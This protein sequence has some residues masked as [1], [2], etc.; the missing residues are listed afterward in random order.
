[1]NERIQVVLKAV[2]SRQGAIVVLW[3]VFMA[4]S[5]AILSRVVT[6]VREREENYIK[7]WTDAMSRIGSLDPQD[8]LV[9]MVMSGDIPFIMINDRGI[10]EAFSRS[11][12]EKIINTPKL[13]DKQIWR[14]QN[15]NGYIDIHFWDGS[16][17][18]VFY[19]K[20]KT[21]VFLTFFPVMQVAAFALLL[22]LGVFTFR[23]NKINEQNRVWVGL[24]K[25]TAHQLGTPTSSLLGWIEYLRTQPIDPEAVEEMGKDLTHLMKIADRFS[26]IGS[27]TPLNP[28]NINEVVGE[29]VMYFRKRIPKNVELNY[30]GLAMAPVRAR[31]NPALF[32]WVIENLLKNALDALQGRGTIDV[33]ISHDERNIFID[34]A[35]SGKGI[36]RSNWKKIFEPGFTTKTRGWGLGLS[37]SHRV[38]EEYHKGRIFVAESEVGNGTTMRVILKLLNS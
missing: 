6:K 17:H 36:P 2:F 21:L 7:L 9:N 12:P 18:R 15:M 34:V 33:R 5:L 38:I 32:E 1:M 35:D 25:E 10:M 8:P 28:A 13:L 30:N 14:Y 16:L 23:S 29:T 19:G 4:L 37:L 22:W 26:K 31:I 3:I 20:S 27:E 11:I 24:A